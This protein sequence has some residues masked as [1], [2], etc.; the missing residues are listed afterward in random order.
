MILN[1]SEVELAEHFR[2]RA[3]DLRQC[4]INTRPGFWRSK[5]I[6]DEHLSVFLLSCVSFGSD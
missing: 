1:V 2:C 5:N 4:V 6:N 3:R